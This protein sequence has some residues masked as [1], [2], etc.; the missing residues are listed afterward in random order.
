MV[1]V[2]WFYP[3]L[4]VGDIIDVEKGAL[5]HELRSDI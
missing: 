4:F 3:D 2:V 1:S 5:T